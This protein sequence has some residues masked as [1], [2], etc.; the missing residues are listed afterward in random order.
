MPEPEDTVRRLVD[1]AVKLTGAERGF[2]LVYD[3]EGA[4]RRLVDATTRI[5][6]REIGLSETVLKQAE[7]RGGPAVH[8]DAAHDLSSSAS[9]TMR[10]LRSVLYAPLPAT[11]GPVGFLYLDTRLVRGLFGQREVALLSSFAEHA[12]LALEN[13]RARDDLERSNRRL[14]ETQAKLVQSA[15]MSAVGQLAAGISHEIRNPLNIIAGSIYYLR[16]LLRDLERPKV[17]E[18]LGSVEDEV[19]RATTLVEKLLDFARPAPGPLEPVD[20]NVVVERSLPLIAKLVEKRALA[21]ETRFTPGIPAI[22]GNGAELQQVLVNLLLNAA[23]ALEPGGK[24]E[25]TTA[26]DGDDG[27]RVEVADTGPGIAPADLERL[28]EPFFTRRPDGTGLGLYVC[29]GIVERHGGRIDVHSRPG[30]GARFTVRLPRAILDPG[31]RLC[32]HTREIRTSA[33][34]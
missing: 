18:Y 8:V 5:G 2:V 15:K 1:L 6:A 27:V 23:Q 34:G 14:L 32:P 25:V 31:A 11:G 28:F 19:R 24:I 9:V 16:E 10:G 13:A 26:P 29:W 20:L 17:H 12:G 21:L 4:Q 30:E 7:S 22:E 3:G 33:A